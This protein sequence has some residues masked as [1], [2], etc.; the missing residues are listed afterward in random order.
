VP[1]MIEL[2]ALTE[3]GP[4]VPDLGARHLPR[5]LQV[6]PARRDGRERVRCAGSLRSVPCAPT[7]TS[8]PRYAAVLMSVL[9]RE[10]AARGDAVL[11]V[12][13]DNAWPFAS[14]SGLVSLCGASSTS[15]AAAA[16]RD[17]AV[18]AQPSA[19]PLACVESARAQRGRE[20]RTRRLVDAH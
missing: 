17:G 11:H 7:P 14:T 6:R 20:L 9:M 16:W 13:S 3:P 5:H 4:F 19:H 12:R 18:R 15:G 2:A 1:A 8:G 10:M